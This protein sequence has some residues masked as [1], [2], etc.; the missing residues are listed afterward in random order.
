[1]YYW[2]GSSIRLFQLRLLKEQLE[3]E[4]IFIK[5]FGLFASKQNLEDRHKSY[6]TYATF[7]SYNYHNQYAQVLSE[8]GIIGLILLIT[9]LMLMYLRSIKHRDYILFMF[10]V[11]ITLVCFT[12]SILWR[13]IGLFL[14][15]GLYSFLLKFS[16]NNEL[17]KS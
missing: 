2:T 7:H 13:Q 6:D 17:Q 16:A 3:E 11:M 5:G 14:F 10:S 9:H 4:P 12:E 8:L 1:M 15:I